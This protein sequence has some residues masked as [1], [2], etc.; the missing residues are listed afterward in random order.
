MI[1][2]MMIVLRNVAINV[3]SDVLFEEGVV[4]ELKCL[5]TEPLFKVEIRQH[6]NI[7]NRKHY[8]FHIGDTCSPFHY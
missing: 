7:T 1:G 4:A 2:L 3:G 6:R 5:L 8:P